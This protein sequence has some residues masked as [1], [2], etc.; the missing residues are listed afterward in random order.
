MLRTF[1][2]VAVSQIFTSFLNTSQEARCL[3]SGW[4]ASP[5]DYADV[6]LSFLF[7]SDER[8]VLAEE[9]LPAGRVP[10]LDGRAPGGEPSP[11]GAERHCLRREIEEG[12]RVVSGN[13][14]RRDV[15]Q[16]DPHAAGGQVP[17]VRMECQAENSPE[18][19]VPRE[20]ILVSVPRPDADRPIPAGG[21]QPVPVREEGQA[22]DTECVPAQRADQ[23]S[24]G[25]VPY[26]DSPILRAG[27]QPATARMEGHGADHVRVPPQRQLLLLGFDVPD[28][29]EEIAAG[30]GNAFAV[31]ADHHPE[32]SPG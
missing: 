21:R 32:H 4:K 17:A 16:A 14:P 30:R 6:F 9:F 28:P 22:G 7:L 10:D 19:F 5:P 24:R 27:E 25:C 29:D 31:R 11:V 12:L 23:T 2:P 18:R 15:P 26:L 8:R 1:F 13:L 20:R 3:P